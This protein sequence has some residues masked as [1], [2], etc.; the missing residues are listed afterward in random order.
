MK[1]FT[2]KKDLTWAQRTTTN[3]AILYKVKHHK[4]WTYLKKK[5]ILHFCNM[6][7]SRAFMDAMLGIRQRTNTVNNLDK[8]K[9]DVVNAFQVVR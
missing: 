1:H 9:A 7:T 2:M 4:T 8:F 5:M 6:Q 3:W